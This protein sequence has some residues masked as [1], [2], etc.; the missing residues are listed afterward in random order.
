MIFSF[1][2]FK[3]GRMKYT[4]IFFFKSNKS[5]RK[6]RE[7]YNLKWCDKKSLY[8]KLEM[9]H[10]PHDRRIK[11][12]KWFIIAHTECINDTVFDLVRQKR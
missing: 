3:L 1:D 7:K 9:V 4:S 12:Q 2:V 8:L 5:N 10:F 11:E 6:N